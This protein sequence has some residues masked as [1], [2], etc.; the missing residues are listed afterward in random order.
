MKI[1]Y[2]FPSQIRFSII[3]Y[4]NSNQLTLLLI[5]SNFFHKVSNPIRKFLWSKPHQFFNTSLLRLTHF[6]LLV[7]ILSVPCSAFFNYDSPTIYVPFWIG[8]FMWEFSSGFLLHSSLTC[9]KFSKYYIWEVSNY[10]PLSVQ[11]KHHSVKLH[12]WSLKNFG[13]LSFQYKL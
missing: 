7:F 12:Q 5:I 11:H 8:P 6:S 4:L 1:H 3:R 13:S 2:L 10:T 9:Q